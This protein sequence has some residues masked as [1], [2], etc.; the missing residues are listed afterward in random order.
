M[1]D[2]GAA[3]LLIIAVVTILVVG[4]RELPKLLRT[5]GKYFGQMQ[6]MARDFRSQMDQALKESELDEMS[7][8]V[9][10]ATSYNPVKDIEDT[11][12]SAMPSKDAMGVSPASAPFAAAAASSNPKGFGAST[13]PSDT[14]TEIAESMVETGDPGAIEESPIGAQ[15]DR[16][17][18]DG[19]PR[20]GGLAA[21]AKAAAEAS[22]TSASQP[23]GAMEPL[24]EASGAA[25]TANASGARVADRV[26]QAVETVDR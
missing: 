2:I 11:V 10:K 5:I 1:F 13:G 4:P 15:D 24:G 3:E 8:D 23:P 14:A 9:R 21:R 6:R 22:G 16:A 7:R 25:S 18:Q 17:P 20:K 19:A 26:A 12:K